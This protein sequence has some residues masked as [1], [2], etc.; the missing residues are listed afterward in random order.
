MA[1]VE[2]FRGLRYDPGRVELE[3][4]LAP[5]YDVLS[6]AERDRLAS[7]DEHQIVHAD[8]PEPLGDPSSY[9][10]AASVL[11][12]WMG[13]G[14]LRLDP[15]PSVY[16][17]RATWSDG[18]EAAER[19]GVLAALGVGDGQERGVLPHEQTTPK[20][21]ADRLALRRATGTDLSPIWALVPGP[22]FAADLAKLAE[23]A[24][25]ADAPAWRADGVRHQLL[26]VPEDQAGALCRSAA[27][28]PVLVAD[29]HHRLEVA[30]RHAEER[31]DLPLAASALA[32]LT[33]LDE[34]TLPRAIHR[35]LSGVPLASLDSELRRL[36]A[37]VVTA[38][39]APRSLLDPRQLETLSG[40]VIVSPEGTFVLRRPADADASADAEVIQPVLEAAARAHPEATIRFEHDPARAIDAARTDVVILLRPVGLRRLQ[41]VVDTGSVLP[42]KS[43]FF[44]PKPPTGLVLRPFGPPLL[45][46]T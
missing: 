16:L 23:E 7:S 20:D 18:E 36:G 1:I 22:D 10:H 43:T 28:T 32:L 24:G 45:G 39:V 34:A 15:E 35:V 37:E 14:T 38:D 44:W 46:E 8:L 11:S 4:V 12:T 27:P 13:E 9:P 5:P 29:G 31:P 3:R 41:A 26:A 21:V 33:P 40:P 42:P 6:R 25:L 19:I 30:R 2:P 17:Y